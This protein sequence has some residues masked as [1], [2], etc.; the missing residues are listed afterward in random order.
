MNDLMKV[1][2]M[3]R[4]LNRVLN[5]VVLNFLWIAGTLLGLVILGI[6]P[7][8]LAVSAVIRE[9]FRGNDDLPVFKTF[10]ENYKSYFKEGTILSLIYGLIGIILIVDFAYITTWEFRV[11][12]GMMLFLYFLSLVYIFPILVHYDL[13]NLKEKIKYSFLIGFSYL[14]YTLLLFFVIGA[15]TYLVA[16]FFPALFT[17]YGISFP[18]FIMM[19][20]AMNVFKIIEKSVEEEERKEK[21]TKKARGK[22][23][24]QRRSSYKDRGVLE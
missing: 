20:N 13:N 18:L 1:E 23:K 22:S 19:W 2:K 3:N 10:I 4:I 6:G 24:A 5:L 15:V 16:K 9:W 7:A 8:T 21:K 17:I 12:F 11:F 14:Q